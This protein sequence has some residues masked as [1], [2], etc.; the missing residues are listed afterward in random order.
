MPFLGHVTKTN[1]NHVTLCY[2]GD[3]DILDKKPWKGEELEERKM[4][5]M[6][7]QQYYEDCCR[8]IHVNDPWKYFCEKMKQKSFH[9]V[10]FTN[11]LVIFYKILTRWI[12]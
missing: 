11:E 12:I 7:Q 2:P 8:T 5:N 9:L 1:Y 6:K 4:Y 10:K 3:V